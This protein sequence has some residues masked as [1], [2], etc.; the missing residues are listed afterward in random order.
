M[1][2][3]EDQSKEWPSLSLLYFNKTLLLKNFEWSSL[4][5]G[6]RLNSSPLKAKNPRVFHGSATWTKFH[7]G[8]S[9][10]IL[11]DKVKMLGVL[12]LCSPS[13]N[14][15]CCTLLTLWCVCVNEWHTLCKA[16]E[17]PCS[18]VPRWPY[19]AY[20]RNPIGFSTDLPMPRGTQYLLWGWARNGQSR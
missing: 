11:Q 17:E 15:F 18:V 13:K 8:G 2:M 19:R 9:S 12:V 4:V 7:L 5:S 20:G 16:S 6:P 10:R 1:S 14:V 3:S